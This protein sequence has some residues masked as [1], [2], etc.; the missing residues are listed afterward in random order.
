L[1][2][3]QPKK[4]PAMAGKRRHSAAVSHMKKVSHKRRSRRGGKRSAIKA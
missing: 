3:A 1:D 2:L 4:E